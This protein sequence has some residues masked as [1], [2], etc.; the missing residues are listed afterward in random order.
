LSEATLTQSVERLANLAQG[1]ADGELERAWA[2]RSYDSEGVR[3]AFFRTYEEV[4][5]L[6]VQ[7][8]QERYARG[9]PL[10][11]AQLILSQYHAAYHDLQA[12]LIG[13]SPDLADRAPSESE[14]PIRKILSHIVGADLGF[15]VVVKYALD[16]NR[17]HDGR[18]E[19]IS[20][21]AW[22]AISG[23]D[24]AAYRAQMGETF[25]NLRTCHRRLHER[26]LMEFAGISEQELEEPSRFWEKEPMS[27]R[28]RLH[29]F[30]SHV[31]QHTIQIDM[32][33]ERLDRSQ[34]EAKRLLRL[35]YGALADVESM[36]IGAEG[37]GDSKRGELAGS[38]D[39]RID[40]I[41]GI[42]T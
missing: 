42:L 39:S 5:E 40:E 3:F 10:S 20:D 25:E 21:E 33:L 13:V 17:S 2:W 32:T 16:R 30:E 19:E 29:R 15:Y 34:S 14:W 31:R 4:R 7:L 8:R 11:S 12:S 1:V 35:I 26:V 23:M 22:D 28:F 37:F 6:A 24:E 18:P 38:L 41:A 27:L 36:Q 9:L